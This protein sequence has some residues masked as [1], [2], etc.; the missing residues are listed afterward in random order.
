MKTEINMAKT[1]SGKKI[2]NRDFAGKNIEYRVLKEPKSAYPKGDEARYSDDYLTRLNESYPLDLIVG[3]H[4]KG[5]KNRKANDINAF[6]MGSPLESSEAEDILGYAL[7]NS[8]QAD[9]WQ[10]MIIDVSRLKDTDIRTAAEYIEE[11]GNIDESHGQ[12]MMD[13]GILWGIAH[14]SRGKFAIPIQYENKV[15]V[16]PSQEFVE[17]CIEK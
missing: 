8:A 6:I 10:P 16:I 2:I 9:S 13:K 12:Y 15:I 3:K 1:A 11:I 4:K 14:A 5:I 7:V 17:F